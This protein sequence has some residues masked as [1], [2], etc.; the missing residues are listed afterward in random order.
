MK[1]IAIIGALVLIILIGGFIFTYSGFYNV[2]ATIPHSPLTEWFLSTVSDRSVEHH[3]K[4]ITPPSYLND[5]EIIK[6]GFNKP[7]CSKLQCG[8]L[9][10]CSPVI[11]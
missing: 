2:A 6:G 3:A 4:G 7:P 1:I 5:Q 9:N 8:L 11:P 10:T